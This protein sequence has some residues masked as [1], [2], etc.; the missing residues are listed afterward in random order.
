MPVEEKWKANR[1]KVAFMKKFPGLLTAWEQ[2]HGK[3]IEA[4]APLSSKAGAAVL[5]FSDG[6][7]AVVPPPTPEP[8]ELGEGLGA[9]RRFLEFKHREAFAEYDRLT[10]QD[11]EALRAARLEKILGAIQNNLE[12]IPE[13]KDRLLRLVDEWK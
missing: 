3:T 1:E 8:W 6:S 13:L 7:F 11:K 5:V 2:A 9:A 10:N 4:V 12:Q